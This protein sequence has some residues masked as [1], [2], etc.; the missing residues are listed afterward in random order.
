[1]P[2][3]ALALLT[4]VQWGFLALLASRLDHIPPLLL[5][6][7]ALCVGGLIASPHY[8]SWRLPWRTF[9]V[10]VYGLFG[11]HFLLFTAFR[12]APVVEANL[13][14]YLWP[15][16][17]V[18][19]TPIFFSGHRLHWFHILGS[20]AG[21][22]GA[23]LIVSGGRLELDQVALPGYLCAGGAA[24]V[25]S[26]YSLLTKRL[27]PFPTPAVGGFC[28]ASGILALLFHILLE[29]PPDEVAGSDVFWLLLIG[30]GPLGLA[31]FTWDAALKKGD[32]R[33]LGALAYLTP[34]LSTLALV[35]FGG[36][37]FTR[38]TAI[39]MVL[40]V[41]GAMTGSLDLFR[42]WLRQLLD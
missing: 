40:I 36:L 10:G 22:A 30:I 39:A 29:A 20:L 21:L 4:I 37:P 38:T 42:P 13:I 15:L 19:G 7:V 35:T 1:M 23:V 12:L 17:T 25:W 18:I 3:T 24:I 2:A 34:L 6:G 28:L 11:Y 27:P 32:P 41:A 8:R 16:L 31:F 5:T 14:N 9:A 26:S 33:V